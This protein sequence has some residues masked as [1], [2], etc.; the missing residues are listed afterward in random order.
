MLRGAETLARAETEAHIR[1]DN[2]TIRKTFVSCEK[3]NTTVDIHL[4]ATYMYANTIGT[5]QRTIEEV[6]SSVDTWFDKPHAMR[7]FRP[8]NNGWT[9]D[10]ILEH[11][12]LTNHFLLII[13][14][15]GMEKALRRSQTQ[16]PSDGESDL[17]F[18][19]VVCYTKALRWAHPEHMTP[20]GKESPEAIRHRMRQQYAEC[21]ALLGQ[22]RNGEGSLHTVRMSVGELGKIDM[23]QWLYFLA[24]HIR[25]HFDQLHAAACEW[26]NHN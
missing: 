21:L 11:I 14:R 20:Q 22:L 12:T 9:I 19:N 7:A 18:M 17:H 4:H 2:N 3:L 25:R 15:K 13:I 16:Q 24:L 23:Y 10:E 6:Y 5:V 26:E 8:S 1:T